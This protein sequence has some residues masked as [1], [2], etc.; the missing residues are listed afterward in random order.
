MTF[1]NNSFLRLR[2]AVLA[3]GLALGF[4]TIQ[5]SFTPAVSAQETTGELQG[6][7]KDQTGAL[8]PGAK[9]TVST[10]TLVGTK[11]LVTDSK[12]YYHFSNLPPGIYTV[13]V[14]AKGFE[15]V[16]RA[17]LDIEVGHTPNL[18]MAMAVGSSATTVEVTS[19]APAIDV[20]SVTTQ[21]NITPDVINYVPH[22]TS[23]Q[24]V[25]QFAPAASNEP[26]MG[27]T[28]TN[29]T[30][31][32]SPGSATNGNPYGYSIAGGSDSENS[33]L[34]EGQET[35]NLIGGYSH[36]NVPF[37]FID[38]VQVKSSGIQ[39]EYGGALGGVIDVIMKKG[40][41]H[42]HGSVFASVQDSAL[43]AAPNPEARYD[44][45]SSQTATSWVSPASSLPICP[46]LLPGQ[47]F[48]TP[49]TPA[50]VP[51]AYQGFLD[52]A[53]QSYQPVKSHTSD[54]FPGFTLGGPL[55]PM[56]SG[57]RDKAFFFVGFNPE[58]NRYAERINYG[59]ASY[60]NAASGVL[61]YSQN[62]NT[63]YTTARIDAQ[64]TQRIRVFGSWLYQLQKQYGE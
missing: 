53:Y 44:P 19:A 40:S 5:L 1:T 14:V 27:S 33:Y 13:I 28:M 10:P 11:S 62:T 49:A 20:T 34:V 24:S 25:I 61:P 17:N 16:K 22:G 36:T 55:F 29:G 57:M 48:N 30:G 21:T 6:T 7:I 63:Y 18:D 31:S 64:V 45:L 47:N 2:T 41:P 39:A 56:F 38:T 43:D 54:F 51:H 37:D 46:P 15:T 4:A 50:C 52:A 42:Y 59:P 32:V 8:I 12:G 9:V 58:L 26:L 35:A 60:G 23:F 3:A